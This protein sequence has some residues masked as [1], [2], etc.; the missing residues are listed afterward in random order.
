MDSPIVQK[1]VTLGGDFR[2]EGGG[3]IEF[4]RG[5]IH[6]VFVRKNLGEAETHLGVVGGEL[7]GMAHAIFGFCQM[8]EIVVGVAGDSVGIGGGLILA[9]KIAGGGGVA[10]ELVDLFR[11]QLIGERF[12]HHGVSVRLDA[13]RNHVIGSCAEG[14]GGVFESVVQL[15]ILQIEGGQAGIEAGDV[16][17]L[18]D[19]VDERGEEGDAVGPHGG[20]LVGENAAAEESEREQGDGQFLE[21]IGGRCGEGVEGGGGEETAPDQAFEI[22]VAVGGGVGAL[23]EAE[24]REYENEMA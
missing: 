11:R 13:Q 5:A 22:S 12:G 19:G 4:L 2:R 20:L 21:H 16:F 7:N 8:V 15:V 1:N 6:F 14:A 23:G 18:A 17:G 10:V 3:L 24:E 9:E